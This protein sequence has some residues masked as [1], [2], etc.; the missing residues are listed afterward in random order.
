MEQ[1]APFV[2]IDVSKAA[3]DVAVYGSADRWRFPRDEEGLV[4]L[5]EQVDSLNPA[6]VVLEATGGWRGSSLPRSP[7]QGL[8]RPW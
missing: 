7:S 8:L 4:Q 2:G 1:S 6:L 3:C 5:V